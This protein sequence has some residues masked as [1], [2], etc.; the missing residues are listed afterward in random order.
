MGLQTLDLAL[1]RITQDEEYPFANGEKAQPGPAIITRAETGST[2]G[3]GPGQL[4]MVENAEDFAKLVVFDTWTRNCDRF[5][6]DRTV[7]R[8]NRDNVFL[9][10]DG[11]PK[12]KFILKAID[13]THCFDRRPELT[14]RISAINNI[15]D[16]RIY[17]LF[18]EFHPYVK[19]SLVA[20]FLQELKR[21]SLKEI[22]GIIKEIPEEWSVDSCAKAALGEFL[23]RRIDFLSEEMGNKIP[24]QG[25][26]HFMEDAP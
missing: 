12:G 7:R 19:R 8:P 15:K 16:T 4:K 13:H 5:Y 17:G 25:E 20:A 9:S 11:A 26:F 14:S 23:F 18:P 24:P 6:P 21:L 3:G 22:N 1:I 2:W 10:T